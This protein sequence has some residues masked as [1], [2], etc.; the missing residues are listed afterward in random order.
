MDLLTLSQD[1]AGKIEC[2]AKEWYGESCCWSLKVESGRAELG[3]PTFVF[4]C[5]AK[6]SSFD[7]APSPRAFATNSFFFLPQS[8]K[9]TLYLMAIVR[10]DVSDAKTIVFAKHGSL[11]RF[12][13][14]NANV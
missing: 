9:C 3:Q 11:C 1:A 13:H 8:Q 6:V 5:H 7:I 14:V 2:W 12:L 10:R 4:N